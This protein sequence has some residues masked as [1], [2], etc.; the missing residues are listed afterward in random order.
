MQFLK[1]FNNCAVLGQ[2][3]ETLNHSITPE[4]SGLLYPP[5]SI[6]VEIFKEADELLSDGIGYA[7]GAPD[8]V[9]VVKNTQNVMKP[10][11]IIFSR[12]NDIVK[13]KSACDRFKAYNLLRTFFICCRK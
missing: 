2:G 1:K 5:Y 8:N 12:D 13:C 6:L 4:D 10:I 9:K 11:I 7:P 3:N